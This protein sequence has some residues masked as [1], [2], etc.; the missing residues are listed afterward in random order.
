MA[1]TPVDTM[2]KSTGGFDDAS[3]PDKKSDASREAKLVKREKDVAEKAKEYER[4]LKNLE[5][6]EEKL[7]SITMREIQ[8]EAAKTE[9]TE[10]NALLKKREK[11]AKDTEMVAMEKERLANE[12]E[13]VSTQRKQ[14][15]DIRQ[16]VLDAAEEQCT[17]ATLA[18][19]ELFRTSTAR[20]EANAIASA[21]LKQRMDE[22]EA[23]D[24]VLRRRETQVA[25]DEADISKRRTALKAKEDEVE[26][27]A[28]QLAQRQNS[29][30]GKEFAFA[31]EREKLNQRKTKLD[32]AEKQIQQN[33]ATTQTKKEETIR[34][35]IETEVLRKEA[36][37]RVDDAN[38]LFHDASEKMT[39]AENAR[40]ENSR[41][42]AELAHANI[43]QSKLE[44]ELR[45]KEKKLST[46]QS[47]LDTLA[48][49]LSEKEND[50]STLVA[51]VTQREDQLHA[52][53]EALRSREE[54]LEAT[55]ADHKD[56]LDKFKASEAALQRRLRD[57]EQREKELVDWMKEMEWREMMLGEKEENSAH[58]EPAKI[59]GG[60]GRS[61]SPIAGP[62]GVGGSGRAEG[63]QLSKVFG[64]ALVEV[65]LRRLKDQYISAQLRHAENIVSIG[66]TAQTH[67][68][69]QG[70]QKVRIRPRCGVTPMYSNAADVDEDFRKSGEVERLR[71]QVQQESLRFVRTIAKLRAFDVNEAA[72]SKERLEQLKLFTESERMVLSMAAN[73]E[74]FFRVHEGFY[75]RRMDGPL[76]EKD[77]SNSA[78]E[79]IA[80]LTDWWREMREQMRECLSQLLSDR[81]RYLHEALA[82]LAS[83][84]SVLQETTAAKTSSSA[85]MTAAT[86]SSALSLPHVVT[87]TTVFD[88]I[89]DSPI[90][91]KRG[92][93]AVLKSRSVVREQ[94]ARQAAA[95]AASPSHQ[96]KIRGRVSMSST[97]DL[98]VLAS[99]TQKIDED[100]LGNLPL[101]GS[102]NRTTPK[103][104]QHVLSSA[105]VVVDD[106]ASPTGQSRPGT[107][108]G[109]TSPTL[110]PPGRT[111]SSIR[112]G[113]FGMPQ[114]PSV[115]MCLIHT[116]R[117]LSSA[118]SMRDHP[119]REFDVSKIFIPKGA[120]RSPYK[121]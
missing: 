105:L 114:D 31:V 33:L 102:S 84:A 89:S 14:E 24:R 11:Q 12:L 40:L 39:A 44:V 121:S 76:D 110:P 30:N 120:T 107:Q 104:A 115:E 86:N 99:S 27:L 54:R 100:P 20:A 64:K 10:K 95:L 8:L 23:L 62:R 48:A 5:A 117:G 119:G 13:T 16:E 94:A 88:H 83:K 78:Q 2:A 97:G 69:G 49:K 87:T 93:A 67:L 103:R 29:I 26:K 79:L 18:A 50:V 81:H 118:A 15:L 58:C 41:F 17:K 28:Q 98:F 47:S 63:D 106:A 68:K 116:G 61:A 111:L 96:D 90:L 38:N 109:A 71:S 46:L 45:K 59:I 37:H 51:N 66:E 57:V 70:M 82:I 60:G 85:T 4:K 55:L 42:S 25:E 65:Q 73:L 3:S 7:G 34:C 113:A 32:D 74:Y 72:D 43:E 35:Q 9:L 56:Q 108:G 91:L 1:Q 52:D 53:L 22:A 36:Q 6:E 19:N 80:K 92:G 77:S 75:T 101:D 112:A 21:Q